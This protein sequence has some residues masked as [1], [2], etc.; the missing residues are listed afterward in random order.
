MKKCSCC[1]G[2]NLRS[3]PFPFN[4]WGDANLSFD[5]EV[6]GKRM[7]ADLKA[8]I[9]M[10]CAHIEW[11]A[12]KLALELKE[13]DSAMSHLK[14]ELADLQEKLTK[15]N[16]QLGSIDAR[17]AELQKK[18]ESL[19]ITV[20]EQ[21]ALVNTIIALNSERFDMLEKIRKTKESICS[22]QSKLGILPQEPRSGKAAY[23]LS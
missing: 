16:E 14:V 18:V 13:M 1:G 20:R 17:L 9:C 11:F 8:L 23:I 22:L 5:I 12:E 6:N 2:N 15:E 10:D 4:V 3:I 7:C 21:K 19:D